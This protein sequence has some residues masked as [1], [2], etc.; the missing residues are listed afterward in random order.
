VELTPF[1]MGSSSY[2]ALNIASL[3]IGTRSY[4]GFNRY[5]GARGMEPFIGIIA[6]GSLGWDSVESQTPDTTVEQT[7]TIG[8]SV[9]VEL[10][11]RFKLNGDHYLDLSLNP[12]IEFFSEELAGESVLGSVGLLLAYAYLPE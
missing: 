8:G 4:P 1:W 11:L 10:G 9:A 12:S 6:G 2:S 3:R 5:S 7:T